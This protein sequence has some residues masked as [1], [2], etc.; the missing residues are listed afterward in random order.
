VSVAVYF[1]SDHVCHL[2]PV[3]T[4]GGIEE[5]VLRELKFHYGDSG[6]KSL[7]FYGPMGGMVFVVS[8]DD[9]LSEDED[10]QGIVMSIINKFKEENENV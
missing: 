10:L 5:A 1:E 9:P 6:D 7:N 2:V 4:K 8:T 3:E